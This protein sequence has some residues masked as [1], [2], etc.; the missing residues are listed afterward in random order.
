MVLQGQFSQM[1]DIMREC[2]KMGREMDLVRRYFQMEI[3]MLANG[4]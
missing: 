3:Y 4:N 2:G 1:E